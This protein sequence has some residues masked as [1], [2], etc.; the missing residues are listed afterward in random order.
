MRLFL[1]L[2]LSGF[3]SLSVIYSQ[4]HQL[5][6]DQGAVGLA[7]SLARLPLIS[8][9][10][11]ITAHPDDE[12]A[13]L[14]TYVS[15]GLHAKTAI[16]SLTRGAGGQ[17]LVGAD[18]FDALG[19]VRTGEM[20]AANEYYGAQQYF[21]RAFDF[22][23]S[24]S[25]KET[26]SKWGHE[27]ILGDMVRAI[28]SF[29]PQ[30]IISVFNGTTGDGHG[31][32][33]A[34]GILAREAYQLSG[35]SNQFPQQLLQGLK[36]WQPHRLYLGNVGEKNREVFS[37]NAGEHAP[38]LGTS[39]HQLGA[40]GYSYHRSQ[41][42][43]HSHASPG[44][45]PVRLQLAELSIPTADIV[46]QEP[47]FQQALNLRLTSLC[48]VLPSDSSEYRRLRTQLTAIEQHV[49]QALTSFSAFD[50]SLCL[51]ALIK[52]L[53]ELRDIQQQWRDTRVSSLNSLPIQFFLADKEQD[54]LDSLNRATGLSFEANI[55][56]PSLTPGQSFRI[57]I[58]VVN[59]S[60]KAFQLK[61]IGGESE[62]LQT[63]SLVGPFSL[64]QAGQ[65][66]KFNLHG[67]VMSSALPTRTHWKRRTSKDD[68]YTID[69]VRLINAPLTP[70]LMKI[71]LDY[72]YQGIPLRM[73]KPLE[74]LQIDRLKGTRRIPLHLV[75]II[76]LEVEPELHLVPLTTASRPRTIQVKVRNNSHKEVQGK[77]KLRPPNGWKVSPEEF[78][79][80]IPQ[81]DQIANF[82][83]QVSAS[84]SPVRFG[85]LNFQAIANFNDTQFT[86]EFRMISVFDRW[87]S[88]LATSAHS[89]VEALDLQI[90]EKLK[91]GYIMGP[92]DRVSATLT[93]L[94]ISVKMLKSQDL[95]SGRLAD[96]DCIVAGIRAYHVRTDLVE[97]NARLLDYVK[98]GGVFLVQYNT[99]NTWNL[100]QYAP[101]STRIVDRNHRVT[102]ETAPIT[103]LEPQHR[104]FQYPNRIT[105]E[106]FSGWVQ[107]RGLYFIQERDERFKALLASHDPGEPWLDGGLL[108][109]NYGK[110]HYILT[111]YSWFR[112]LPAGVSGAIR[113]FTNLVSLGT[114]WNEAP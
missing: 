112:Q 102:D 16:L 70:P 31:H 26:L 57:N 101:F 17:N 43:G 8:R 67:K 87:N 59:R 71:W 60:R 45:Y 19:L 64:L 75:P 29:R 23:F 68:V 69:D 92:G 113:L 30:I 114:S 77:L 95:A 44:N 72:S 86:E 54:F 83:F 62:V 22:G 96:Y 108:V 99:P 15:R 9:V 85:R 81:P 24:K 6:L 63:E 73:E 10:L 7:Q 91:I 76:N 4:S 100:G 32:H 14:V 20:M 21:T 78:F 37:I 1:L 90:P 65:E 49:D 11:F 97:Y 56:D 104:V 25:A 79:F 28:R 103:I 2:F 55:D 109:A 66:I 94:G 39:F 105:Q 89:E 106:D 46:S 107:E 35:N 110:G 84:S 34:A 41:G 38:L 5:F 51:P 80:S 12:P 33:Q 50:F 27:I 40:Q 42:M 53:Q 61:G 36:A 52:G 88:L 82:Q 98:N 13:G 47:S 74:Y 48:D 111:S 3:F 93:Q 18:L 58:K